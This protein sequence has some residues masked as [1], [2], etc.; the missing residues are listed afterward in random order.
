[1]EL[2]NPQLYALFGSA[3]AVLI[4]IGIT[5]C[6]GLKTG[7]S[8]GWQEGRQAGTNYWR[9]LFQE[10]RDE[11][12]EA[13]DLRNGDVISVTDGRYGF[14]GGVLG[15]VLRT[16]DALDADQVEVD[17]IVPSYSQAAAP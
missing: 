4:L 13:L 12:L 9:P 7:H 10:K 1:M 3:I 8:S 15:Q 16:S 17:F 14:S 2:T 5:Y 11:R 6:A